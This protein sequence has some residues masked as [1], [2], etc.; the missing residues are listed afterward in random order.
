MPDMARA[1]KFMIWLKP[2]DG[3]ITTVK[4]V[5]L[6]LQIVQRHHETRAHPGRS[7]PRRVCRP[8]S[9]LEEDR[10]VNP[11]AQLHQRVSRVHQ[12]LQFNSKKLTLRLVG[13]SFRLHRIF[14][15]LRTL[16]EGLW[17]NKHLLKNY[18]ILY[19]NVIGIIQDR[20]P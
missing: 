5:V 3:A 13:R 20:L 19:S 12:L 17:E 18:K 11:P 8:Q 7:G 10:P 15:V 9:L 2:D 16:V 6:V 14:P 4:V 1:E